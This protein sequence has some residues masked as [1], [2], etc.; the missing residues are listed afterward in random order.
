MWNM[1]GKDKK[2]GSIGRRNF[3]FCFSLEVYDC[4]FDVVTVT[5]GSCLY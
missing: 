2:E 3:I 4:L 5:F 1:M